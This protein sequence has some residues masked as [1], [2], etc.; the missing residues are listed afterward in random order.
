MNPDTII[1]TV[2]FALV[3][4]ITKVFSQTCMEGQ[5]KVRHRNRTTSCFNCTI[6]PHGMEPSP[7][8]SFL[9]RVRP[10]PSN[11]TQQQCVPCKAGYYSDIT[12]HESCQKC[13]S[14]CHSGTVRVQ[15]CNRTQPQIC[16][17]QCEKGKYKGPHDSACVPCCYCEEKSD[18]Y[19]DVRIEKCLLDFNNH[20]D[21]K[22]CAVRMN[23]GHP[24]CP[25]KAKDKD[26]PPT[27]ITIITKNSS[28]KAMIPVVVGVMFICLC[29]VAYCQRH[30][31]WHKRRRRP[32]QEG[33]ADYENDHELP[34]INPLLMRPDDGFP[35]DC[36]HCERLIDDELIVDAFDTRVMMFHSL[37]LMLD[38]ADKD[39]RIKLAEWVGM[40]RT[41]IER[42][43]R[44][45]KPSNHMFQMMSEQCPRFSLKR[46]VVF[47][48]A[49]GRNDLVNIVCDAVHRD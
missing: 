28:D 5:I 10:V 7:R 46:L 1:K 29:Y 8:C 45:S 40:T 16:G 12:G 36:Q 22:V 4:L 13:I 19:T 33:Q 23:G 37:S 27:T 20:P 44:N 11:L 47:F 31:F 30:R 42:F 2:A 38:S 49:L 43:E 24:H 3:A 39:I 9:N 34:E 21:D 14:S 17:R 26:P 41:S 6:C 35:I 48:Q 18:K 32:D 15:K 25:Q